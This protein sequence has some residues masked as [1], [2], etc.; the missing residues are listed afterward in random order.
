MV[1]PSLFDSS[2]S[3]TSANDAHNSDCTEQRSSPIRTGDPFAA[4][5]SHRAAA[6]A[7]PKH[8]NDDGDES[9][10]AYMAGLLERVRRKAS[11]EAEPVAPAKQVVAEEP[12]AAEEPIVAAEARQ[13]FVPKFSREENPL[14][15]F[16]LSALRELAN[17]HA[18]LAID[19]HSRRQRKSATA[20][21]GGLVLGALVS[22]FLLTAIS[23]RMPMT[24]VPGIVCF[25]VAI[26]WGA[27]CASAVLSLSCET[28]DDLPIET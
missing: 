3:T 6:E 28:A 27:A 4:P 17:S 21:Q 18:D 26:V 24:Y 5:D 11:G 16:D 15:Q 20:R 22:G 25:A 1:I 23:K 10:D 8:G 19:D 14:A 2:P 12:P 7:E 13:W 9:I